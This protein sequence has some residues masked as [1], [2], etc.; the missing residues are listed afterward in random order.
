MAKDKKK[1]GTQSALAI[2]K[3][4]HPAQPSKA[5]I[6]TVVTNALTEMN[7]LQ[8]AGV[9]VCETHDGLYYQE[10]K[11]KGQQVIAKKGV[12]VA[13]TPNTVSVTFADPSASPKDIMKEKPYVPT[14]KVTG[15]FAGGKSQS[16]V[17]KARKKK[18]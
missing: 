1:Q 8:Q 10:N 14:Q 11:Q 6:E 18:K 9:K 13:K 17:S 12:M 15:I 2:S 5:N 3:P 4:N 7:K 16:E